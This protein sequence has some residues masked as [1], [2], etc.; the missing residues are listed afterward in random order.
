MTPDVILVQPEPAYPASVYPTHDDALSAAFRALWTAWGL[1]PEDPFKDWVA[2]GGRVVIKPNWVMDFN[3]SGHGLD[4]L[5]THPAL[6]GHAVDAAA[7]A[8]Q[9]RGTVVIGDAPLQ[10]CDFAALLE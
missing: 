1:N 7:R 5:I 8:L 3:P 2:P 10:R 6:L 9:G 4:C